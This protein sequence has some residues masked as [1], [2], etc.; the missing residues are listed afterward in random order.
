MGEFTPSSQNARKTA[1]ENQSWRRVQEETGDGGSPAPRNRLAR[2][3][4]ASSGS[5]HLTLCA[6]TAFACVNGK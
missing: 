2:L 6:M 5:G 3:A 4:G 1:D